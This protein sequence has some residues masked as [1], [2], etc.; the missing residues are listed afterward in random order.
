MMPAPAA[1]EDHGGATDVV[2]GADG[3]RDILVLDLTLEPLDVID[4]HAAREQGHTLLRANA[5]LIDLRVDPEDAE[6]ED[7]EAA[8]DGHD[9]G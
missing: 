8:G 7:H 2:H 5:A 4:G 9:K 6:A 3:V 1:E